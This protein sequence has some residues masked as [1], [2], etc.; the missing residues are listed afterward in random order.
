MRVRVR[1]KEKECSA[2]GREEDRGEK[3]QTPWVSLRRNAYGASLTVLV[4]ELQEFEV[5]G[6]SINTTY[7]MGEGYSYNLCNGVCRIDSSEYFQMFAFV[8]SAEYVGTAPING[9]DCDTWAF[10]FGES[11]FSVSVLVR[12]FT[13]FFSAS[14]SVNTRFTRPLRATRLEGL[15]TC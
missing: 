11:S 4:R 7:I 13:H 2:N 15:D 3:T 14:L 1:V 12:S 5:P 6:Y 10:V 9:T 8:A